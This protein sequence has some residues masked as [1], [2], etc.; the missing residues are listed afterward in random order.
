M[1]IA[2]VKVKLECK[3]GEDIDDMVSECDYEFKHESI[4]ATE[5]LETYREEQ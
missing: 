3:D 5:I 4:V 2:Y 1:V